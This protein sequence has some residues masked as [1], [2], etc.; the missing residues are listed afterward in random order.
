MPKQIKFDN[1]A[2]QAL[3]N[4][5]N[6]LANVVKVTLGPKGR[7][8][9]LDKG[10]GAPVITKDGV[11]VAREIE[12]ED[13]FENIGVELIKEVANKTNDVVGDGTTTATV[14]VQAIVKEGMKNVT[15]GA[16]PVALNRGLHKAVQAIV[17]ELHNNIS[18]QVEDD[19]IAN[20]ASI[21]ANDREIGEKIAEAM[22]AVGKDG[23]ITVEDS[24]SFGMEIETVKGMRFD[25]GLVS[26][27]M[28]TNNERMEA[29][30]NDALILITDK[31]ISSVEDIVPILEK[32]AESGR[33]ELVVIAEDVDGQALTTLVLNKLR[34]TFSVLAVKAPGFGDRRKD[35]LEDI[36]ILTGGKVITEELGMKLANTT[37]EDLGHARKVVATKDTTTIVGGAGEVSNVENRVA[38]IRKMIETADGEFDKEKLQE[39]LA[40]LAGGVAVIRVGAATETEMK[41]VKHRI[42][43]AVGATKAATE[44]GVVPGGGVALIRASRALDNL[45]LPDEEMVAV[46]ILRRALEEPLR[47]IANNAG[48]EGAVVVEE[49]KRHE[50]NFG[51]NAATGEYED[52]VAAGVIDPTKVTRSALENAVSVAGMFLT[53]EAVVTDLPSKGESGTP[54]MGGGMGGMM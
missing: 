32:V 31:K 54:A 22:K 25:K 41:E 42:E 26:Q 39:R 37:L 21:S 12:L 5:V 43:D 19:E 51:F 24:Q 30:Y 47:V 36:A 53:T 52:M 18:K 48:F 11:S 13:K 10:Y 3:V 40:K 45:N 1:D 28:V 17:A 29:E 38:Q 4:G 8:V 6:I 9:V 46:N 33:K 27:Y 16:N 7:N 15:A 23:V 20:V 34:G 2:R 44:E 49:V 50:G 35:M 14:L